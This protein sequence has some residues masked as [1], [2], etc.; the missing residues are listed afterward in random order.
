MSASL[1]G[2]PRPPHPFQ[3][4]WERSGNFVVLAAYSAV[5]LFT[6]RYHEKWADEAQ[7]WLLAR[8]LSLKTL[9][10]HELRYEGTPG[11]WHT[12]L[13]FAQHICHA[14]YD[15]MSYIGVAF[16]IA[17]VALFLFRAPFPWYLRWPLVFTYV[18]VYQYAVIARPYTLFPLLCFMTALLFPDVRHPE[19]MTAILVL[20][21]LLSLHGMIMAGS[22]GLLY[23][24][25]ALRQWKILDPTLRRRYWASAAVMVLLFIFLF[26]VLRPTPDVV[27]FAAKEEWTKLFPQPTHRQKLLSVVCGAFFDYPIPSFMFLAFTGIWCFTR[28]NLAVFLLP[29]GLLIGLYTYVH[30]Y[31]HHHGTVLVATITALWIAWPSDLE[32]QASTSA[33]K[34]LLLGMSAVLFCLCA[35][36][37]MDAAVTIEREYLYPYSGAQEAADYLKRVNPERQPV[38]GYLFGVVAL[39]PYF[40]SNIFANMPTTYYHQGVPLSGTKLDIEQLRRIDPEFVVAYS[41]DPQLMMDT[42]GPFWQSM[43]Y[44]MVHFA[45]G[46]YLYKRGIYQREAYLIFRRVHTSDVQTPRPIG[47]DR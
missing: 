26:L 7:A 11:L 46:Y 8:D 2:T 6:V 41:T 24:W 14:S 1:T 37:I 17:G 15:S 25:N 40:H 18:M 32:R 9:W 38:M 22:I 23:F 33:H 45:D 20:L 4:R 27:E 16:A 19:S 34:R 10:F 47:P 30:G 31:A 21:A 28:R 13:W 42:D 29:V 39:Q 36:N 43:G 5:V 3:P 35:V 44:E 12:I